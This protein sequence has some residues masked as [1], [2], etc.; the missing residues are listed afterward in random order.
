[1]DNLKLNIPGSWNDITI[2]KYQK[3]NSMVPTGSTIKDMLERTAILIDQ[4][5]DII[6]RIKTNELKTILKL[7]EW[8]DKAEMTNLDTW[9]SEDGVEYRLVPENDITGFEWV[10]IEDLARD[11]HKNVHKIA[12]VLVRP[13]VNGAVKELIDSELPERSE[14]FYKHLPISVVCNAITNLQQTR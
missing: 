4:P 12:A 1:M 13:V 14:L 5:S 6:M 8:V 9:K 3:I 2:E 10:A 7:L 11:P